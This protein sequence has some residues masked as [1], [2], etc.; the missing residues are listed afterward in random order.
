MK[1]IKPQIPTSAIVLKE[2]IEKLVSVRPK[3]LKHVD[4]G[5]YSYLI[6]GLESQS[7]PAINHLAQE[8]K[9]VR[10][11]LSESDA[12]TELCR[13]EFDTIRLNTSVSS[14]GE[15]VL[16]RRVVHYDMTIPIITTADSTLEAN[17]YTLGSEI[18]TVFNQHINSIFDSNQG[19][20]NHLAL[21][22][23][24]T[25][26]I[27]SSSTMQEVVDA[28]NLLNT[29]IQAHF[30]SE[31][32]HLYADI[33]SLITVKDAFASNGLTAF[34]L[35][36]PASQASVCK[37]LNNI[38][39]AINSHFQNIAKAG[40][41]K[42][43]TIWQIVSDSTQSPPIVGI[44]YNS[45]RDVV[46]V[47]G[48]DSVT[49]DIEA[50]ITGLAGNTPQWITGGQIRTINLI[51]TLFDASA[52]EKFSTN[53]L[54]A[55]GGIDKESDI[56]LRIS[57][58]AKFKGKN[59][60]IN[61]ALIA[62][63]FEDGRSGKVTILE[64]LEQKGIAYVYV[65]DNFWSQSDYFL[66]QIHQ[67]IK[68]TYEGAGCKTALGVVKNKLIQLEATVSLRDSKN[69]ADTSDLLE[70]IQTALINYF[71]NRVDYYVWNLNQ[72]K[73]VA[74]NTDRKILSCSS[75]RVRDEDGLLL[76]EPTTPNAGDTLIH[77]WL[78]NNA[79]NITFTS[80]T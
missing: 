71:D 28:V 27:T 51:S 64:E 12:L 1:K 43:G 50:T 18:T 38:K 60:P 19:V 14:I 15:V 58:K 63:G 4:Q 45:L 25:A 66:R 77:Y 3:A 52:T 65:V 22:S 17:V 5:T 10:L 21:D 76:L 49:I 59:S 16:T 79:I 73:S 46:V 40:V 69:L 47:T 48:Q 41:I 26:F 53:D 6:K 70:G 75:I 78:L 54:R 56:V 30:D 23:E 68:T 55:A 29:E 62:G 72:L 7:I 57:S 61:D 8:A 20:G 42:A 35:N 37:L 39:K 31:I 74:S 44:Q 2:A 80:A 33:T 13:S 11:P 24:I 36:T 9:A 32:A 67:Q 34:S